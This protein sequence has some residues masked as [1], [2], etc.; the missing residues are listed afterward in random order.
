MDWI[1][2]HRLEILSLALIAG[3]VWWLMPRTARLPKFAG[4]LMAICG[5]GLLASRFMRRPGQRRRRSCFLPF[6]QRPFCRR[7]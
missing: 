1:S 2:E 4:L 3:G 6:R 7:F 5:A